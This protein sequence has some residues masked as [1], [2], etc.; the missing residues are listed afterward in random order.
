MKKNN[1][2]T[3]LIKRLYGTNGVLDEYK[4]QKI[5]SIGNVSFMIMAVY[6][7]ISSFVVTLM[8]SWNVSLYNILIIYTATNFLVLMALLAYILIAVSKLKLD[9]ISVDD[10]PNYK[11]RL[12]K[13]RKS[14]IISGIGFFFVTRILSLFSP[15]DITL[16]DRI[17]SPKDN[18]IQLI[19]ALIFVIFMYIVMKRKIYQEK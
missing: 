17:V 18:V 2:Y 9:E 6:T 7:L 11:K 3:K 15:A 19:E 1:F 14:A 13:F 5:N 4:L 12:A 8:M 10:K 16:L